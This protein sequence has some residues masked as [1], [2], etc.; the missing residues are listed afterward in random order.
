MNKVISFL[1]VLAGVL[2]LTACSDD[3]EQVPPVISLGTGPEY[4]PDGAVIKTGGALHFGIT[5]R[6]GS[7]NITNLVIKKVLPGGETKVVLDSGMNSTGFTVSETF[8]QN[9]EDTADWVFQVMDKNRLFATTSLTIYKDPNSEWG[10]IFEYPLIEM[11]F[12]E[13]PTAGQFLCC[14]TGK[15][16][17]GDT[18][19]LFPDS[20]DI[21]TYYY[22]DDN[23]PSPTFSSP[24]ET[25]GGILEYYPFISGW[26]VKHY[27]KWDIS[28]DSDPVPA[29][30]Y[31]AC[32]ND[33][34]L[35]VSYDDV[36]GKRKFKWANPGD[37]IPFM[38]ASGKKGLIKVITTDENTTGT[39]RFSMKVQQ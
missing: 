30:A 27:T 37:I 38:T 7:A 6:P 20:V 25:G 31:D 33:S 23:L 26:P 11:G 39:I 17:T 3:K 34:L 36:W 13:N 35:I 16:M 18:A 29:D 10:G 2:V 5:V 22:E 9:V 4:T 14:F 28:V 15:V 32:H 21:A 19:T 24:G 12:Q 1:L 8:Y